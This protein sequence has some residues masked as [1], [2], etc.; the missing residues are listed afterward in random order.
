[1]K[2]RD[3]HAM[4]VVVPAAFPLLPDEFKTAMFYGKNDVS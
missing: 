1:M 2:R 3:N 4:Q